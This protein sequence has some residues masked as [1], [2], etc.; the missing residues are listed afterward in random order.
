MLASQQSYGRAVQL[1]DN[2]NIHQQKYIPS[3]N[4]IHDVTPLPLAMHEIDIFF[5]PGDKM[6]L[7]GSFD[8]LVKNIR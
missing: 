3:I 6:V 4:L 2:N 5:N 8:K 1:T 7:K